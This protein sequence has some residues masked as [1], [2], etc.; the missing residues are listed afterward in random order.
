MRYAPVPDV[1]VATLVTVSLLACGGTPRSHA[2]SSEAIVA[3]SAG[4]IIQANDEER[5]VR[6]SYRLPAVSAEQLDIISPAI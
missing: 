3:R 5:R 6:R 2:Q 4:L 1:I